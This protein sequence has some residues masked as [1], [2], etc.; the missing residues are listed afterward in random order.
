MSKRRIELEAEV[1]DWLYQLP[2]ASFATTAFFV[3][4]LSLQGALLSRPYTAQLGGSFSRLYALR[5]FAGLEAVGLTYWFG[6]DH[7]L[8]L[9]TVF[10]DGQVQRRYEVD[11]AREALLRCA[12]HRPDD[13]VRWGELRDE[14]MEAPSAAEVFEAAKQSYEF[15]RTVR[16][17]REQ[18]RWTIRTLADAAE[19][20]ESVIARCE[21]GGIPPTAPVA[22]RIMGAL[23]REPVTARPCLPAKPY[24]PAPD[25]AVG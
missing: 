4:V 16:T 12:T 22:V 8:V 17:A 13:H 7:R 10:R 20:S 5:F 25:G 9:L 2:T 3:S 24:V 21:A 19:T 23:G 15:A 1:L 11:R 18:R 6:P 14:R